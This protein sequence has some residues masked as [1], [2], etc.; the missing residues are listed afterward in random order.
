M[1]RKK[2]LTY[3]QRLA[4]ARKKEITSRKFY[5]LALEMRQLILKPNS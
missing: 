4:I 2:K 1:Y 3:R 5:Q